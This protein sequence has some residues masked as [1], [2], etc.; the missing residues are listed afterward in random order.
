M[1]IEQLRAENVQQKTEVSTNTLGSMYSKGK[2]AFVFQL[3]EIKSGIE[4]NVRLRFRGCNHPTRLST[5][6]SP[7]FA[8]AASADPAP[9]SSF[10]SSSRR[11][12]SLGS[13]N[14]GGGGG[15]R[16]DKFPPLR[17]STQAEQTDIIAPH[18]PRKSRT[19]T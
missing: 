7:S 12:L 14:G 1:V 13:R 11:S 16:Q 3:Q 18:P 2:F 4:R 8:S 17:R 15:G 5:S 10:S 19:T 9:F 6:R